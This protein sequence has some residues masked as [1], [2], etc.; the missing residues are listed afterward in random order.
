M[1]A[2]VRIVK[3]VLTVI[4]CLS[5]AG[6][7]GASE[8]FDKF[9]SDY[10]LLDLDLL[11]NVGERAEVTNFVYQKDVATFTFEEGFIHMLRYVDGRPT[12]AIFIGKGNAK[13][14]IPIHGERMSLLS[15]SR[16]SVVNEDFEVCLIRMAD[17]FDLKL[18]EQFPVEEKELKWK[19]FTVV[20]QEQSE[21]YFKPMIMHQYDNYF[22]LLRSAYE[23]SA[24]GYFWIDFDR[25]N[26]WFDPNAPEE[27]TVAYVFQ[28]SEQT[29][30]DAACFQRK[31]RGV[32]EDF[33]LSQIDY[34]T[35][36]ISKSAEIEMGGID[37]RKIDNAR[38]D[39]QLV[40][41]TDSSRFLSTF[42]HFNLNEDSIYCNGQRVDYYRRKDFTFTG[43]ILPEYF[44]KG[45]TITLTFWYKG[46][47]FSLF[48]PWVE[49]PKA[50]MHSLSFTA[51]KGFNYVM[52]GMGEVVYENGKERFTATPQTPYEKFFMQGYASGFDTTRVVSD[53]G[54]T[55]NFLK[56]SHITKR[57]SC[58]TPDEIYEV[59]ITDAFNFMCSKVGNP[60]N[61]FE[62]FVYPENYYTMPGLVEVPQIVCYN[63]GGMEF[64]GGFNVFAGF[65]VA[66]QWFGSGLRPAS[67]REVWVRDAASEYLSLMFIQSSLKAST[68]YTNLL[69][70]RDTLYTMCGLDRDRPLM[71]GSRAPSAI[72]TNKGVWLF[73][74]LRSVMYDLEARSEERFFKFLWEL[75]LTCNTRQYSTDDVVKLA[76]KHYGQPLDWFFKFWL[77]GICY[78]EFEVEY[79]YDKRTEGYFIK[80]DVISKYVPGDFR[81]PVMLRVVDQ[82]DQSTFIR[83][84]ITGTNCSFEL[85]PFESEPKEF[86]FNELYSVLSKDKVKKL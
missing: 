43:V 46:K 13:I 67:D 20:K 55:L 25:Y 17:D 9:K 10:N 75:S 83:R 72:R 3:F 48:L 6:V 22:Q 58:Y 30:T 45:D 38:A 86:V 39:I 51:P 80:A 79:K 85:G 50:S 61:T 41:N 19:D 11:N 14:D 52:P 29:V 78:P 23:R 24:D 21:M 53:V 5:V 42:L 68:Y 16:D 56:A 74:M 82:N 36:T 34:P 63:E 47:D 4:L 59:T 66:K 57:L 37:G 31:E 7:C 33:K 60:P 28:P 35:T 26:F 62:L 32:Y 8:F 27:V 1:E 71:T 69:N 73:H 40:I 18:K 76:E 12:T 65:S 64:M 2:S 49:D 44:Y 70:R 81:M 15:I 54:I 84:D 77:C